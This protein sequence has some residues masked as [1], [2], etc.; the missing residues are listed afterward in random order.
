MVKRCVLR[1]DL[2]VS[3]VGLD[4]T[5]KG[6]SFHNL[7]AMWTKALSAKFFLLRLFTGTVISYELVDL[8]LRLGICQ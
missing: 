2:K 1:R 5:T 7:G 8:R 4:L 6:S 3:K